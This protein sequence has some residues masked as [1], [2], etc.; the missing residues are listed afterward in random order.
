M[1][2]KNI[3]ILNYK[4]IE[5]CRLELSSRI[6][7]FVGSNGVGKTNLLDAIYYLSF[8]KSSLGTTDSNNTKHGTNTMMIKGHYVIN[9]Q[10]EEIHFGVQPQTKK[11]IKRN[12]K[13]YKKISEHI[14]LIPLVLISPSAINIIIGAADER[15]RFLDSVISQYDKSYLQELINYN[16]LL[17]QRNKLLKNK[18]QQDLLMIFTEQMSSSATY[19]HNKRARFS[20][21]IHPIFQEYHNAIGANELVDIN[22]KSQLSNNDF[23]NLTKQNIEKDKILKHTTVG[24]HRDDIVLTLNGYPIKKEGSQGQQ[25]TFLI[26]LKLAQF[27]FIKTTTK[28]QPIL[29]LDDIFDRLDSFRVNKI[30]ELISNEHFG[31]IFITDT[32]KNHINIMINKLDTENRIFQVIDGKIDNY[33]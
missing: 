19:I 3:D 5:S 16:N 24:I 13:Q 26:A 18:P 6:N 7:C 17:S 27:D 32:D 20:K 25:K 23:I 2:L 4:N 15:R 8:C 11:N 31:Q 21:E 29:L 9:E 12:G 1:F 33:A 14:G 22:Y 28:K 10:I 30:M